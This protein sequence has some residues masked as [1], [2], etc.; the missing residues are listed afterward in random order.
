MK[1]FNRTHVKYVAI[2]FAGS[3]IATAILRTLGQDTL[4]PG[5]VG[6]IMLSVLVA[7]AAETPQVDKQNV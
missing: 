4:A 6:A 5:V 7:A 3:V 1:R 2:G